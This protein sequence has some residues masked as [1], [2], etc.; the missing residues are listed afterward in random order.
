[1]AD[2]IIL[3]TIKIN[4]NLRCVRLRTLV[5]TLGQQ[6][7]DLATN[8]CLVDAFVVNNLRSSSG[9]LAKLSGT[10]ISER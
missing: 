10:N 6:L 2:F 4:Y 1:M 5:R 9:V 7:P 3:S 8:N